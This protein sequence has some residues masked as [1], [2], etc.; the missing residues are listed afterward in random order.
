MS[1]EIG[2]RNVPWQ[3]RSGDDLASLPPDWRENG[4]CCQERWGHWLCTRLPGHD[5]TCRAGTGRYVLAEWYR[6]GAGDEP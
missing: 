3:F 1:A 2:F 5:G 6:D 4:S